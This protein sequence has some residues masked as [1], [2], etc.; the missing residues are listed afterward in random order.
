[1]N[2]RRCFILFIV[3]FLLGVGLYTTKH[4]IK[5]ARDKTYQPLFQLLGKPVKTIDRS[6]TRMAHVSNEEESRLAIDLLKHIKQNPSVDKNIIQYAQSL[7]DKMAEKHNPKGLVWRV[8]VD[9]LGYNAHALPGGIIVISQDLIKSMDYEDEIVAILAHE[10]GHIDL[11]HCIDGYRRQAKQKQKD[12]S[13]MLK[14][15]MRLTHSKYCEDEAD[16][17]AFETLIQLGYNVTALGSSFLKIESK[18]KSHKKS[19][20]L[21]DYLSSHP[22]MDIRAKKWI[23]VGSNKKYPHIEAIPNR[24]REE[25]P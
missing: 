4:H 7:V 11:G 12:F 23:E 10:K 14:F 13:G 5:T 15:L 18:G 6:I 19:N 3:A 9:R 8:F 16:N 24:F 22:W 17:Y 21:M 1:M 20:I 2:K 25:K